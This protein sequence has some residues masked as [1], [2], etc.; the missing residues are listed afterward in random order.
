MKKLNK[1]ELKEFLDEKAAFYEQLKFIETDPVQIPHLF[2]Q[3][4]D[5]EI[6]GFLTAT[7]SWGNRK[8][9]LKNAHKLMSLLGNSPHDYVMNHSE[10]TLENLEGFVH[11]TFNSKDLSYF[12]KALQNIYNKFGDL[13]SFFSQYN[14]EAFLQNAIH[15]FKKEFFTLPHLPRTQKHISDPH[16]N[17]AAKRINMFLRWMIR[18]AGPGVDLGIWKNMSPSQLSCPLDVHSGN[19]ARKLNL[20]SR[21]QNDAKALNQLDVNLR[22]LDPLDPV[23]YDYALFGLGVFEKF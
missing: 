9:I 4:E 19:V 22:L 5:I 23:K 20:L 6:A 8:S 14:E 12:I 2:T 10:T 21:N 3:K 16:K 17:S 15:H 18:D 13:E 11:R 1:T 7:I